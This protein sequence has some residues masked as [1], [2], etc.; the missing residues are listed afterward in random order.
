MNDELK[1][2]EEVKKEEIIPEKKKSGNYFGAHGRRKS[3]VARVRLFKGKGEILVNNNTIENYFPISAAKSKW[4]KPFMVTKSEGQYY[5]TI[6]VSGSGKNSQLDAV[7]HGLS[8]A[9]IVANPEFRSFL[10]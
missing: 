6:K 8:R 5:A 1:S 9:L 4:L 10:K 3:A 2:E 7:V